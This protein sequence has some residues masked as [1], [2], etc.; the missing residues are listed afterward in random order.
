MPCN[1]IQWFLRDIVFR[2]PTNMID[3][4]ADKEWKSA[5]STY[6][7]GTMQYIGSTSIWFYFVGLSLV[8]M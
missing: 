2:A 5:Q 3:R 4:G 8:K 7:H 1:F 6:R